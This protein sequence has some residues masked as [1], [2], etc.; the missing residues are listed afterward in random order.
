MIFMM[1]ESYYDLN[2][3]QVFVRG[4]K[5]LVTINGEPFVI[6]KLIHPQVT[7]SIYY[8]TQSG[9]VI[10]NVAEAI[11]IPD[12]DPKGFPYVSLSSMIDV[13]GK[14]IYAM[15]QYRIVDLVAC[16]FIRNS[17][18]YLERGCTAINKDGIKTNNHYNNIEYV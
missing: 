10:S 12:I 13:N 8:I 6:K 9:L 15:E 1:K 2:S 3:N 16:N 18:C 4:F 5:D 14:V 11:I 7:P 17:D